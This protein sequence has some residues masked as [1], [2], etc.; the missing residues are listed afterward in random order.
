MEQ[1]SEIILKNEN[2]FE[3]LVINY[4]MDDLNESY[5]TQV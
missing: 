5:Y 3:S 4:F 1:L 2:K